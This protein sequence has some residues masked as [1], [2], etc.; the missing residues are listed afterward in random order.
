MEGLSKIDKAYCPIKKQQIIDYKD[1]YY[2]FDKDSYATIEQI[3]KHKKSV[4]DKLCFL[5]NEIIKRGDTHDSS[6]LISPE[7]SWLIMMDKEP[8]YKYGS[9]EYFDK[10]DR[11]SCF[12]KHHYQNN[13]HH[14][15]HFINGVE[16][17]N[18]PQIKLH[19]LDQ[20]QTHDHFY[21]TTVTEMLQYPPLH[22]SIQT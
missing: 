9:K 12:F 13:R 17:M 8:K 5:A 2:F 3:L 21:L 14:P 18:L 10:L 20:G 16:D 6:K 22:L 4:K 1:D 19:L 15:D 7:I 11:W